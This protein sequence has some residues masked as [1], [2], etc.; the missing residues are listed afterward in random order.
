MNTCSFRLSS[1]IVATALLG[2]AS[3]AIAEPRPSLNVALHICD[4]DAI[5]RNLVSRAQ[6]EMT[7]IYEEAGVQIAWTTDG[8]P[9]AGYPLLTLVI[10]CRELTDELTVDT[11]ALGAAV[12]TRD[13]RGR[14][15]YVFYD[16][17]DD[18]AQTYL[19]L[20]GELGTNDL[21]VV[22]VLAHAMAHEIGHLLLPH[23]HS[24]TG[25]MQAEW[26]AMD[27]R[28]AAN[29]QL[30]FTS[31]QAELI[32]GQLLARIADTPSSRSN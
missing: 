4:D 5:Q 17:V 2:L 28:L 11:T 18:I 27:L 22:I 7:R 19:N 32:R 16:R 12:G 3:P 15:A 8:A 6:V 30:N 31:E 24:P 25:L 26:D 20:S 9:T 21:N 23:G 1:L 29:R 14:V 10:L 13:Y